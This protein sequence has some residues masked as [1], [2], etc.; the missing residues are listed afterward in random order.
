MFS[1]SRALESLDAARDLCCTRFASAGRYTR[2]HSHT[3]THTR[4]HTH[5]HTHTYIYIYA[6]SDRFASAGTL[7]YTCM[8]YLTMKLSPHLFYSCKI[9][10]LNEWTLTLF[11]FALITLVLSVLPAPEPT[12]ET[13]ETL[14]ERH[15]PRVECNLRTPPV[16]PH[17]PVTRQILN[18]LLPATG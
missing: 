16:R 9:N 1:L 2:T 5:T 10:V 14:D 11:F 13:L 12:V 18:L 3:H 6:I 8:Q 15:N 4:T 17:R 7:I